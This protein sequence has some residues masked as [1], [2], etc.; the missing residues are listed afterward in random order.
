MLA[1]RAGPPFKPPLFP[2]FARY[3][4]KSAGSFFGAM[5]PIVH[6][7]LKKD[8]DKITLDIHE[9]LTYTKTMKHKAPISAETPTGAVNPTQPKPYRTCKPSIRL[10]VVNRKEIHND[11]PQ[12]PD[13]M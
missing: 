11:L 8:K 1:A 12:L 4:R 9:P 7:L 10:S 6:E 5:P 3:A 13:R 2:I